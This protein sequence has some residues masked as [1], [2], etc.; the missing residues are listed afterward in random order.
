ME[1]PEG[2][3][4]GATLQ[5]LKATDYYVGDFSRERTPAVNLFIAYY[6]FLARGEAI[7]SPR[8]CLPGAGWE[9]STFEEIG[10]SNLIP[11][12]K[13][14]FNRVVI[15]KGL[16]KMLMYYWFQQ[17]ERRTA[18]EFSMKYY[19]LADSLTKSRKD[20]ALVRILTPIQSN[21]EKGVVE[22]DERLRTFIEATVP[23][24]DAYLPQ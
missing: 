8:V 6:D 20:G 15:Q 21:T 16:D 11:G 19:L 12:M 1:R 13:G 10:F 9:F 3:L 14:T 17:R 22:A 7:H 18:N 24:L 2:H 5:T 4:D 23:R